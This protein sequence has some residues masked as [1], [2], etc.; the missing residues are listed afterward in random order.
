MEGINSIKI[1][2]ELIDT[3]FEAGKLSLK[4]R[5]KELIKKGLDDFFT[6]EEPLLNV[7]ERQEI[8]MKFNI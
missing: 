1:V 8:L 7:A 5:D 6:N 4:I 3:F 2:D